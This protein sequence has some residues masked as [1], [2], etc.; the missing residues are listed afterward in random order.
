VP[1]GYLWGGQDPFLARYA[2]EGTRDFVR[3]PYTV[4]EL[5]DA[6]HW[7]PETRPAEVAEMVLEVADAAARRRQR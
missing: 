6:G 4:R 2:A 7:L 1:T 5:P 3:G